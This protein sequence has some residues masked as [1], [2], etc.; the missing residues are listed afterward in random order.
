MRELPILFSA[1]MVHAIL[2]GRK[3]VTRRVVKPTYQSIE[4]RD[5]GSLWPWREDL[6][7]ATDYWY[8]CPYGA[9]GD[10]LWVRETFALE[11][12]VE[13]GEPPHAD[14]RPVRRRPDDD[15]DGLLPLWTQA[16][17]RATD[18]APDLC[19]DRPSCAQCRDH[20]TGPHWRPAIHMPRWAS[21]ITLEVTAVRVERLQ[22]IT[23]EQAIAEGMVSHLREH[24]AVVDLRQQFADLWDG[25]AKPG[26]T[27]ADNPWV[28][29]I[30]FRLVEVPRADQ[31]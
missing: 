15:V 25:L 31:A 9:P 28:W 17:Y 3:T 8:P 18:P 10:R 14:G 16:H 11:H 7:R 4:E 1:P 6:N 27:W 29:C 26:T 24:D 20:D 12:D 30:E 21:R 5:D 13:G 19:C 23:A 2:E 22:G